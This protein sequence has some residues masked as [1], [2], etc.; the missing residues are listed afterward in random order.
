MNES[1]R[2]LKGISH[3]IGDPFYMGGSKG[4]GAVKRDNFLFLLGQLFA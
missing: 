3:R 4:E 2:D 1:E